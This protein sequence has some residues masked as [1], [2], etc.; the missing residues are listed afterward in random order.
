MC[1]DATK[2][3]LI[4]RTITYASNIIMTSTI[5]SSKKI[6]SQCATLGILLLGTLST[7][8]A[9]TLRTSWDP[10]NL[11]N[12]PEINGH[13]TNEE[14]A[15]IL[16]RAAAADENDNNP[17]SQALIFI[18]TLGIRMEGNFWIA[19]AVSCWY[20]LWTDIYKQN[21]NDSAGISTTINNQQESNNNSPFLL[22]AMV[23]S[24]LCFCMEA[25]TAGFLPYFGSSPFVTPHFQEGARPFAVVWGFIS[26]CL[27][28]GFFGS[29]KY[30][31]NDTKEQK[32]AKQWIKVA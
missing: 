6:A 7:I 26:L 21:K 30:C 27:C 28:V 17:A 2:Q 23:A 12:F 10:C 14:C 29:Q 3:E 5:L 13:M 1:I 24:T 8:V 32:M 19:T 9:I 16:R 15:M 11:V 31:D 4:A 18:M 20:H 25:N 22:Y